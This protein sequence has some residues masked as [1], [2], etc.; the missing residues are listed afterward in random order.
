[1]SSATTIG[2]LDAIPDYNPR[3]DVGVTDARSHEQPISTCSDTRVLFVWN[4]ASTGYKL[5]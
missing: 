5:D 1:V 2:N 4:G 3:S